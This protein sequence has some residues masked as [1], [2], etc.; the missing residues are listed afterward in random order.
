[1]YCIYR[2]TNYLNGKTYIGQHKYKKTPYDSYMGSGKH[3]KAA[4][5]KYGIENFTKDIIIAD[6]EDKAII[7]RLEKKYIAFERTSNGNGC[8]NIADGGQGGNLGEEVCKRIAELNRGRHHSEETRRKIGMKSRGRHHSEET[9]KKMSESHKGRPNPNKGK[10]LG[11]CS[12]E[13]K[14]RLSEA[15]KGKKKPHSE[16]W[17]IKQSETMKGRPSPNRGKHLSEEQKRKLSESGKGK[18]WKLVDGKRVY[19]R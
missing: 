8:Y 13:H 17:K 11:P 18:H 4:Q 2:I 16:E 6:I 12:E 9:R 19:Y 14:R 3:L 5:K 10:K 1:M 15:N 7:D